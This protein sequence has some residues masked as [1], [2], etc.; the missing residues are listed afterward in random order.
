VSQQS[1]KEIF[2]VNEVQSLNK[3]LKFNISF[4]TCRL[5]KKDVL[6]RRWVNIELEKKMS[7]KVNK[8]LVYLF[9]C[10]FC[11][12]L[13][14]EISYGQPRPIRNQQDFIIKEPLQ[15]SGL[16][17]NG[18]GLKYFEN[19]LSDFSVIIAEN[20]GIHSKGQN[21]ISGF[22]GPHNKILET[23]RGYIA[24]FTNGRLIYDEVTPEQ[25]E[26]H[27]TKIIYLL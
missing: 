25:V 9:V 3:Q 27:L 18:P 8:S 15:Y 17:T 22:L 13:G 2:S 7:L 20:G 21:R 16:Y 24:N 10:A 26:E 4:I 12:I 1:K 5:R 11:F 23:R 6:R 19:S 14:V